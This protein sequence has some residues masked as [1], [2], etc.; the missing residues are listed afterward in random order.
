MR[1]KGT[2]LVGALNWAAVLLLS[3]TFLPLY[4]QLG[5]SVTFALYAA[6]NLAAAL[7]VHLCVFETKGRSLQEIERELASQRRSAK[8]KPL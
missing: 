2:S 5:P 6:I 3:A 8:G 4:T 1:G 7:F